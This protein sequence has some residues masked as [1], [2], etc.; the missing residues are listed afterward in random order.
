MFAKSKATD[1]GWS[2]QGGQLYLVIPFSKG[3]LVYALPV[4]Q[5]GIILGKKTGSKVRLALA[6]LANINLAK[7]T[8]ACQ[9]PPPPPPGP[10]APGLPAPSSQ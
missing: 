1:L 6:L 2:V 8:L 9:A 4:F 7:N 10:P 3:S 5:A